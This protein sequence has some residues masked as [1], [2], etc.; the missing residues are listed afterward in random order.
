MQG[1]AGE[2]AAGLRETNPMSPRRS[3]LI[4]SRFRGGRLLGEGEEKMYFRAMETKA[5]IEEKS[6]G[7]AG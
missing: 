2:G 7:T 5:E 6:A 3:F 1:R 4:L